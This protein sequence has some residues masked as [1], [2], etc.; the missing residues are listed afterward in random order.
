MLMIHVFVFID[1]VI[2]VI[3]FIY[4][5][6]QCPDVIDINYVS[7]YV[8]L[9]EYVLH[10]LHRFYGVFLRMKYHLSL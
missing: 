5:Y 9:S 8:S 2:F 6:M 10:V 1:L 4:I 3:T 7:V